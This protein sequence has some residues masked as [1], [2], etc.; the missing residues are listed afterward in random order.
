VIEELPP[1]YEL[2]S[3]TKKDLSFIPETYEQF[4]LSPIKN[5]MIMN[6]P[7]PPP[8]NCNPSRSLN[9]N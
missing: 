6:T 2:I 9:E 5:E 8:Y 3:E 7:P 1:S 4:D